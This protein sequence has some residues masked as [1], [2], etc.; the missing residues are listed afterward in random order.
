MNRV[1][2]L[3]NRK[4]GEKPVN[5]IPFVRLIPLNEIIADV[6]GLGVGTKGVEG[7]YK[8]L[9][10]TF[11]NEF[12]IL[13]EIKKEEIAVASLPEIAEGVERVR[14]GKVIIRPGYDGEFGKISIFGKDEERPKT[15][16]GQETLFN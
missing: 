5:A 10:R 9:I 11:G 3:A 16:G 14:Q 7:Y 6:L 13:L 4:P 12:K 15:T 8:A 1:R 2:K